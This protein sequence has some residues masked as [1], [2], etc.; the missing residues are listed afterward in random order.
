[1]R[2]DEDL[3]LAIR[4]GDLAAFDELYARYSGRLF[5]Y[6]LRLLG[7]R[8][9]AEDV[10]QEVFMEV[11]RKDALELREKQFAGWLFTV[12]R[13]RGLTQVRTASRRKN[14][15][16]EARPLA[17]AGANE[18]LEERTDRRARIDAVGAVLDSLSEAHR[19][20]L[21][22]K[23]V[24]GFTYRQIAELQSVPE[25]TAK[26]R[27]HFAVRALRRALGLDGAGG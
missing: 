23:E 25:G 27:L 14:A 17:E 5:G 13:N 15:L 21:L 10:F 19:E 16:E 9:A 2:S 12:A 22:L 24:G 26:S 6:L 3:V 8:D 1:M 20:V 11:L 18:G 7:D 4:R